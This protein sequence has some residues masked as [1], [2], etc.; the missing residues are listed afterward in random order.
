MKRPGSNKSKKKVKEFVEIDED[1]EIDSIQQQYL[2]LAAQTPRGSQHPNSHELLFDD[3]PLSSKTKAGL[4]EEGMKVA[5]DI[6]AA[7]VTHGLLGRDILGAA[8]TGTN[9]LYIRLMTNI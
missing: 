2:E 5:T 8:K 4:R 9:T 3:L 6:Q 1:E 7:A